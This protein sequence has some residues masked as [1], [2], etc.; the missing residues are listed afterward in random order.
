MRVDDFSVMIFRLP[1]TP[2]TTLVLDSRVQILRVFPHHHRIHVGMHGGIA[3]IERGRCT[4]PFNPL[5]GA[6]HGRFPGHSQLFLIRF[7][8]GHLIEAAERV[9]KVIT[10][11]MSFDNMLHKDDPEQVRGR[12][13]ADRKAF[14]GEGQWIFPGACLSGRQGR[15]A[16]ARA[17]LAMHG[18]CGAANPKVI[19]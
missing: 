5:A 15:Q 14:P 12:Q 13:I 6:F 7:T 17:I 4:A 9:G 11:M 18:R 10:E 16:T 19:H 8:D 1:M 2:G 3:G